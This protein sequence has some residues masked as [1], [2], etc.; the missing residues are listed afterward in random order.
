MTRMISRVSP[1]RPMFAMEPRL[2]LPA[3]PIAQVKAT[4]ISESPMTVMIV[5]VTTAGNSRTS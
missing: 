5:P 3:P 2:L 4:G 1:A